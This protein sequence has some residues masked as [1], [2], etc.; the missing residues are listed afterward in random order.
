M[1]AASDA[2]VQP[3]KKNAAQKSKTI[4]GRI[5][6]VMTMTL[7]IVLLVVGAITVS[8]NYTS[9]IST[10]EQTLAETA[11]V[12]S[13]R[14]EMEL[15]S[16]MNVCREVGLLSSL[17][18]HSV[19]V[20][21]KLALI[22]QRAEHYGFTEGDILDTNGIS[23]LNGTDCS[24]RE[25]FKAAMN[26]ESYMSDPVTNKVTGKTSVIFAAPVRQGGDP[27]GKIMGAVF[28]I[29]EETFLSDIV[30]TIQVGQGG[31][32]FILDKAGYTIADTNYENVARKEHTIDESRED[33]QLAALAE[34]E[35][36]MIAGE[37]GTGTYSYG[38]K[39]KVMAYDPVDGTNG[40]SMGVTAATEEFIQ[41]TIA[42]ITVTVA[43]IIVS[44][45]VA[46]LIAWR[47]ASDIGRPI[48][49]CA[50]RL[51]RLAEGDLSSPVPEFKTKDETMILLNSTK[52]LNA[53]LSFVM[54]DMDYLL[55]HMANGDFTVESAKQDAYV[56]EFHNLLDSARRLKTQMID[57]LQ[58]IDTAS[59]QVASG[60]DQV[61]SGAQAL[62]QGSTEQAA[63]VEELSATINDISKQVNSTAGHARS[64]EEDDRTAGAEIA[65]C[66]RKMN[67]LVAAMNV[68]NSKSA[69]ISKVIKTIEDIAFQTNIL[70]LNAAVEAARAGA[71]GKGFAVVADEVRNLANKS[72]EAAGS[73]TAL[74][75][76]TVRA[77][78]N[79]SAI[80]Q[81]TE[82]S[83]KKVVEMFEKVL[84]SVSLISSAAGE[85]A[86]AVSQ[87]TTGIDQI[88]SVVQSN[89]ATAEQSAAASEEL[90]SQSKYLKEML[91]R[92]RL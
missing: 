21:E 76:E 33:P 65:V 60:A 27:N 89:S 53:D 77:V 18:S 49:E 63:S 57:I 58:K 38:G 86:E 51:A 82:E 5:M 79:G 52:A 84:N 13:K 3:K 46:A 78:E 88:S 64:A 20:E 80:S 54:K 35:E 17:S 59:D 61:S 50:A 92:F 81:E 32:A 56:G 14:V 6:L 66:S 69:E 34:L 55:D 85:Q 25:Y 4:R 67:E 47:L 74:I 91:A 44:L 90:N 48:S 31:T 87:V 43:A 24:G 12:A 22:Q 26:G 83:L 11:K 28:F 30:A 9:T 42:G 8:I 75:D 37:T 72:Q 2:R 73:T 39:S 23:L 29:P 71:A 40:W 10:L 70:A 7:L 68:I 16:Y 19:S 41:S 1:K 36:H 62:A 45:L 15:K